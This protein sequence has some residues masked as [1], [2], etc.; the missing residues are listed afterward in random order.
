MITLTINKEK[1]QIPTMDELTVKQFIKL[2]KMEINIVSYLSV[3]LGVNYKDAFNTKVKGVE[4]LLKRLGKLEDYTKLPALKTIM[5]GKDL[6]ALKDIDIS[7]IGQ[8]HTIEQNAKKLKEEELLC[9]IM[10]VGMIDDPMDAP[11][12]MKLKN[13]LM[14]QPY[15]KILPAAFFLANRFL[16]GRKSVMNY[17]KMQRQLI[18]MRL[19]ESKRALNSLLHT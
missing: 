18:N 9:Y 13:K 5:I 7:T 17:L 12:V 19:Y 14:N 8:R 4:K 6:I 3:T 15:K 10:A 16:T 11:K 2:S 1:K